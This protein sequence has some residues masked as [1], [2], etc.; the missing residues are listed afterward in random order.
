[1]IAYEFVTGS[2][3]WSLK[4]DIY[5]DYSGDLSVKN[6]KIE[7]NLDGE[8]LEVKP[9]T[10]NHSKFCDIVLEAYLLEKA[11]RCQAW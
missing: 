11:E 4:A 8:W 2:H 6:L 7:V 10:L 5:T 1:M 9:T 3:D